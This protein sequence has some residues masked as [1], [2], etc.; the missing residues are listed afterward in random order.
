MALA[1]QA[2]LTLAATC[3]PDAPHSPP[4]VEG[5]FVSPVGVTVTDGHLEILAEPCGFQ[6]V[7]SLTVFDSTDDALATRDQVIWHV[8]MPLDVT[9]AART[10][11]I[12]FGRVPPGF[13]ELTPPKKDDGDELV[14]D[15]NG[16]QLGF[17][18]TE[19]QEGQVLTEQ[20]LRTEEEFFE[21]F[22]AQP[23]VCPYGQSDPRPAPRS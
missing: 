7:S 2:I 23:N 12:T 4:A 17:D 22:V 16:A 21:E 1:L 10:E 11:R 19:L 9:T 8:R 18:R 3:Q 14:V 20:G 15:V 6:E 5:R 13:E